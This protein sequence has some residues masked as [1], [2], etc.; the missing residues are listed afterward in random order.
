MWGASGAGAEADSWKVSPFGQLRTWSEESGPLGARVAV[1]DG[2]L[3]AGVK[4]DPEALED[5][6][7]PFVDFEI[8]RVV[9]P[10]R[11]RSKTSKQRAGLNP[12]QEARI[13][14]AVHVFDKRRAHYLKF[15]R[16]DQ[17]NIGRMPGVLLKGLTGK[18]RDEVEQRF[19]AEEQRLTPNE[20]KEYVY[21]IFN[22]Q[23]FFK[24]I[25][26]QRFPQGLN[27]EKLDRFFLEDICRLN[28]A[29]EFWGRRQT[30]EALHEYLVRYA[31]MF[32]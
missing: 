27:Q 6:F 17:G 20:Q 21:V 15:G 32:L 12:A 19:I 7:W 11:Q 9:E 31:I 23:R 30:R 4:P 29:P 3:A 24:E 13:H 16:M 10:F 25:V 2:L 14:A 22:L 26:A 1:E 18:S 28:Q 8:K 5:I